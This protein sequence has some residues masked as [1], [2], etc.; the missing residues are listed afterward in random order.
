ML[1]TTRIDAVVPVEVLDR[2][3]ARLGPDVSPSE[4]VRRALAQLAGVDPAAYPVRVGRPPGASG[5]G[6]RKR[7]N[8]ARAAAARASGE[9]VPA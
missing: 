4:A 1:R 8:L 2:A 9:R 3:R 5:A 6:P 7:R